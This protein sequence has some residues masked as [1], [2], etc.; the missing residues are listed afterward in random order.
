MLCL[1]GVATLAQ[2]VVQTRNRPCLITTQPRFQLENIPNFN[3]NHIY[4]PA[5]IATSPSPKKRNDT[6][7]MAGSL[8]K[9][10]D[11]LRSRP[12]EESPVEPELKP[13]RQKHDKKIR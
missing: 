3:L 7:T 4:V 10:L 2:R 6:D 11:Q 9:Y 5:S 1:G 8:K 12:G 13:E